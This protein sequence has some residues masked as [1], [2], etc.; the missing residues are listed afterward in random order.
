MRP[1]TVA[2]AQQLEREPSSQLQDSGIVSIGDLTEGAAVDVR[3]R[4]L[5]LRMVEEVEGIDAQLQVHAF[6]DL[7]GLRQCH[8]QISLVR[9]SEVVA[10]Q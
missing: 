5:E 10:W 2:A 1:L 4:V 6:G 7:R 9:A 3:V 8:V